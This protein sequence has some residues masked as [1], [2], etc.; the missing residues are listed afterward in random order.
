MKIKPLKKNSEFVA[1]VSD[2]NLKKK[3]NKSD[4]I[5]SSIATFATLS[6]FSDA[7]IIETTYFR[8]RI[9]KI[10]NGNYKY[11]SFSRILEGFQ[12]NF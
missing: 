1:F 4:Q 10:Y 11:V 3:L 7:K 12:N 5:Y 9:G 8:K 2:I 6:S